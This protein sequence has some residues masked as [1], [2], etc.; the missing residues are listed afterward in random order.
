MTKQI[1]TET[2][3]TYEVSAPEG[4]PSADEVK[5]AM[6]TLRRHFEHGAKVTRGRKT[7]TSAESVK[8]WLQAEIGESER[9]LFG[10]LYLDARNR[11]ISFDTVFAGSVDR[12]TVY[13]R[14]VVKAA[15]RHNASALILAHNHPSGSPEPSG[16]DVQLTRRLQS[17]CD[18][19]DI[20]IL[21]HIV[22]AV[23]GM[24]SMAERG[25]M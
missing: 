16:A 7:L 12:A 2:P 19:L 10:V 4:R 25:Q 3:P 17:V 21:D 18:E 8:R 11:L 20:R 23:E 24:V 13:P 5:A 15:L 9:E 22:I 1:K 14:E 6:E